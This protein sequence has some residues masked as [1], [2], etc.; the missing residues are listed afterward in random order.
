MEPTRDQARAELEHDAAVLADFMQTPYYSVLRKYYDAMLES[1]RDRVLM[2]TRETFEYWQGG[3]QGARD[4]IGLPEALLAE[5][6]RY[7]E[8]DE[9]A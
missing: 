6:A 3:Y 9:Y 2:A 8:L 1:K 5:V 7:K 4:A